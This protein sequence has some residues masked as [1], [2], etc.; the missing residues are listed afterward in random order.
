MGVVVVGI[1]WFYFDVV[2]G[3]YYIDVVVIVQCCN[4]HDLFLEKINSYLLIF[5]S[6][7]ILSYLLILSS[8]LILSYLILININ[9]TKIFYK[10]PID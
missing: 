2:F 9:E 3:M 7:L 4:L 5:L 8:Y 10:V 6:Y 1:S